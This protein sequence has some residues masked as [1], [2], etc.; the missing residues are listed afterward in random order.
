MF[1]VDGFDPWTGVDG[2]YE[3]SLPRVL[4]LGEVQVD[5]PLSDRD[6]ILRKLRGGHDLVFTN[7]DQAVLGKRRWQEG[8]RE[9]VRAFWERTLFYNYNVTRAAQPGAAPP[10]PIHARLLRDMLSSYKPTHVVVWGDAN[11]RAIAVEGAAWTPEAE[12]RCGAAGEPCRSVVVDGRRTLFTRVSHPSAGF[13]HE[14]WS[15]LLSRFLSLA[16]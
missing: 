6:C 5:A 14:R 3:S 16:P 2:K 15:A 12:I 13:D 4:V 8:Y 10:D 11:W 7:F 1:G 9:A